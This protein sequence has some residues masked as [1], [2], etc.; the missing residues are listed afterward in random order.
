MSLGKHRL[1]CLGHFK[2]GANGASVNIVKD[3]HFNTG[4]GD[5]CSCQNAH[6]LN[7]FVA[8]MQASK[9]PHITLEEY[10]LCF[11]LTIFHLQ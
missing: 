7:T 8:V 6:F 2:C 4:P 5:M 10:I 11:L 3:I 1:Y 9:D